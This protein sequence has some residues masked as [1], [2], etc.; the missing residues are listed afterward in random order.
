MDRAPG[1]AWRS[2]AQSH[3]CQPNRDANRIYAEANIPI[4]WIANLIDGRIEV[5][6]D[7]TGPSPA[8]DYRS[9]KDFLPGDLLP[10][11]VDG[12]EIARLPVADVLP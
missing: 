2:P 12:V 9:R 5:Y 3:R 1:D 6:S 4:Y 7:P 10:L 8:P 11:D